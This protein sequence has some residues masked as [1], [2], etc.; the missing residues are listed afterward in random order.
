[1]SSD[2]T[3]KSEGE[4]RSILDYTSKNDKINNANTPTF[5]LLTTPSLN[6]KREQEND[7]NG[8]VKTLRF[9]VVKS[10]QVMRDLLGNGKYAIQKEKDA[11]FYNDENVYIDENE[12]LRTTDNRPMTPDERKIFITKKKI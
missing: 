8:N 11:N 6:A 3:E 7:N 2:S 10:S 1:M 4:G 5:P 9:P 12:V